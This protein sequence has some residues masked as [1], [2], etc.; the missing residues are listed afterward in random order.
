M[1]DRPSS[2]PYT[3]PCDAL[4]CMLH[5]SRTSV[6]NGSKLVVFLKECLK[7]SKF[8]RLKS[9]YDN[10]SMKNVKHIQKN[11]SWV[12]TKKRPK[13][14]FKAN[15][16]LIQVKN[17]AEC[18]KGEHSAKLSTFIKLTFVIKIFVLSII[19]WP[20]KT[21]FIVTSRGS[22]LHTSVT[23]QG[24]KMH[25]PVSCISSMCIKFLVEAKWSQFHI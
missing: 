2:T 18:S 24:D 3:G 13:L 21:G 19:E 17:I 7:K 6:L 4:L 23:S 22:K 14:V 16:R 15:Y 5:L 11:L 10:K 12:A 8:W 1:F 9:A 25:K 20:L